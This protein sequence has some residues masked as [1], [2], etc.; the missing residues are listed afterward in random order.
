MAAPIAVVISALTSAALAVAFAA[1]N[2]ERAMM[3][4]KA[5][6]CPD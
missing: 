3:A 2:A 6:S 5:N 4:R 1:R